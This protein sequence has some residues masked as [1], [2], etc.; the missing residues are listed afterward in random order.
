MARPLRVVLPN[1]LHHV[2]QREPVFF[3][4]DDYEPMTGPPISSQNSR[5]SESTR[6]NGICARAARWAVINLSQPLSV[7]PAVHSNRGRPDL[8]QQKMM[9]IRSIYCPRNSVELQSDPGFPLSAP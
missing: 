1:T 5:M 7:N 9:G 6:S 2:T 4:D 3:C 8:R